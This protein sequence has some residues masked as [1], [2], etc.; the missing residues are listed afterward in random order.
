MHICHYVQTQFKISDQSNAPSKALQR[1]AEY[2]L[3][4]QR[5]LAPVQRASE[6]LRNLRMH[7]R[8]AKAEIAG[9]QDSKSYL[10][11]TELLAV[12]ILSIASI[13]KDFLMRY[14]KLRGISYIA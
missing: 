7:R 13:W 4:R 9:E 1:D 8:S 6:L 14:L 2:L 12:C 3:E 10:G 11:A 5:F